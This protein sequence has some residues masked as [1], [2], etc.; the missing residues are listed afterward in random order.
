MKKILFSLAIIGVAGALIVGASVA[1]F[2]DTETSTGNKFTAGKL[3]LQIDNTC[4]YN[5]KICTDGKWNGTDESCACNWEAKDLSDE[6]FFNLLDVM[7]GDNGEDTISLHVDNQDA[8]MCA[9]IANVQN[10]DNGCESPENKVDETCGV[11][12]GE[13]QSNMFF[14][15]WNDTD[16]DNEL[17][18]EIV[19][20]PAVSAH[21]GGGN[22][23]YQGLCASYGANQNM[24]EGAQSYRGCI[25][26]P[27][28]PA[29][30]AQA[31]ENVLVN[32]QSAIAGYWPLADATTGTGPMEGGA[33]QCLGVKWNVPI[34]TSN[35]IQT[36]SVA[37]DVKFTA[38]Q[39]KN[40]D[41]FK[42]SDLY[43]E[44]CDG[45]DNDFDGIVDD[46]GVCWTSPASNN[47]TTWRTEESGRD[48]DLNTA[49]VTPWLAYGQSSETLLYTFTPA[50]PASKL[51]FYSSGNWGSEIE[52]SA[53]VD[54][55]SQLVY[56]GANTYTWMERPLS[57]V[58]VV[59]Q[60][61]V[62]GKN[63]LDTQFSVGTHLFEVQV[64]RIP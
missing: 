10:D 4:H 48:N 30:P 54:G 56:S 63:A 50:I 33:T 19:A 6:L 11:G 16:C 1:Y 55:V 22:N 59:S 32:N 8:W 29:I 5:D 23:P 51:R 9:I 13:L 40:M 58:G 47:E 26:F 49:T 24:C 62:V 2:S 35:I 18:T 45:I 41:S 21:C 38:V 17:D 14:T 44:T 27:E 42:C 28:A 12:Q 60:V 7:P 57:P 52:I 15:V 43:T 25:W 36:D 64:L 20:T 31:G 46:G 3:N 39:A 53:V 34:S 37:G 61:D